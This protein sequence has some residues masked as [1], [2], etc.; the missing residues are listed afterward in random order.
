MAVKKLKKGSRLAC[1]PCG[2]EVIVDSC[3]A[4]ATTIWCCGRPMKK[5]VK[6]KAKKS[7]KK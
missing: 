6:A 3:G 2:R 5:S 4:S 1:I 7:A